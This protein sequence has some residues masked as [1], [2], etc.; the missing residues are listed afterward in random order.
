MSILEQGQIGEIYH[1]SP[2]RGYEVIEVVKA[3]CK[4]M[5]RSFEEATVSVAER[6]GQD[7]A[8]VVDSSKARTELGWSPKLFLE[9]GLQSVVDW[10]YNGWSEAVA[11][12]LG[13]QHRT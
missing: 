13:Y 2:D 10:V 5:N 12:P 6:L 4:G 9:R 7:A 3:I 1:L 11:Q 8:Y